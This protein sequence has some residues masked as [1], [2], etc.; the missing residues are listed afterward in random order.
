MRR[1]FAVG[2]IFL[3]FFGLEILSLVEFYIFFVQ[4]STNSF[5]LCKSSVDSTVTA[6]AVHP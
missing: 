5:D 6:L 2:I 4:F 3:N 1:C